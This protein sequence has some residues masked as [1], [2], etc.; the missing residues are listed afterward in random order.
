M[1]SAA[2]RH[3][4]IC[5]AFHLRMPPCREIEIFLLAAC[6]GS[7]LRLLEAHAVVCRR[8]TAYIPQNNLTIVS[9]K[10]FCGYSNFLRHDSLPCACMSSM[11]ACFSCTN[12]RTS[13]TTHHR[14][15]NAFKFRRTPGRVH[16]SD[17]SWFLSSLTRRNS[18]R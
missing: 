13:L 5:L 11:M 17:W 4:V 8:S 15:C 14:N 3:S 9:M 10:I 1:A 16:R 18:F 6:S 7:L 12:I 2:I